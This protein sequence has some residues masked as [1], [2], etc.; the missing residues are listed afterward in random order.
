MRNKYCKTTFGTCTSSTVYDEMLGIYHHTLYIIYR[1]IHN[2]AAT[3]R[4]RN[5]YESDAHIIS[6]EYAH[7]SVFQLYMYINHSKRVIILNSIAQCTCTQQQMMYSSAIISPSFSSPC[8]SNICT[9]SAMYLSP[10]IEFIMSLSE[11]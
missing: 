10:T 3:L 1:Y 11:S 7:I 9:S 5:M 8:C 4:Y 6:S 2:L